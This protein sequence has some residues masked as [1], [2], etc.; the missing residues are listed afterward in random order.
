[1]I[2]YCEVTVVRERIL[3]IRPVK[4]FEINASHAL[5]AVQLVVRPTSAEWCYRLFGCNWRHAMKYWTLMEIN[6]RLHAG[7][8]FMQGRISWETR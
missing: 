7:L 6:T 5:C 8:D 2:G 3:G 4:L 1:M